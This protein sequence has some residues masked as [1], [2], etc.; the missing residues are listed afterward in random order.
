MIR[1]ISSGISLIE[2]STCGSVIMATQV[3]ERCEGQ[4]I[5]ARRIAVLLEF[6]SGVPK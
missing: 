1:R 4:R 6:G 3:S 2:R 5:L